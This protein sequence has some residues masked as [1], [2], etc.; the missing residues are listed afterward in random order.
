ML[1]PPTAAQ[2]NRK[3]EPEMFRKLAATLWPPSERRRLQVWPFIPHDQL[4]CHHY[5]SK[6]VMRKPTDVEPK[7]A[8]KHR[9]PTEMDFK[10]TLRFRASGLYDPSYNPLYTP[11][12][13]FNSHVLFQLVL[14]SLGEAPKFCKSEAEEDFSSPL[15]LLRSIKKA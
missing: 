13:H 3:V 4:N 2:I 8:G 9:T 1:S 15:M 11:S 5:V 7:N 6:L 10:C 12:F 14:R